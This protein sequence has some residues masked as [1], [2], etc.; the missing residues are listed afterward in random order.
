MKEKGKE[1]N[2]I[3]IILKAG[4]KEHALLVMAVVIMTITDRLHVHPVMEPEK[5]DTNQL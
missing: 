1:K 2:I 3:R 4:R 5:N